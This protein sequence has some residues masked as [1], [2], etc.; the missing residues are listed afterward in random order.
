MAWKYIICDDW[1]REENAKQIKLFRTKVLGMSQTAVAKAAKTY[2]RASNNAE[3]AL[4]F[5]PKLMAWYKKQG[6]K[7][8][9]DYTNY[10]PPLND[11][12]KQ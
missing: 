7:E 9:V 1:K 12:E 6:W 3:R 5:N 10:I 4:S 11:L 8:G 2:S